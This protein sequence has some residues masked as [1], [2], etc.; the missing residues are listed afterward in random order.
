LQFAERELL[1][2]EKLLEAGKVT[3]AKVEK[4]R[5]ARDIAAAELERERGRRER[6]GPW[7]SRKLQKETWRDVG[8]STP[9]AALQTLLWSARE[10]D[11]DH[12]EA[13]MSLRGDG[14]RDFHGS[15]VA[16]VPYV[17]QR[18]KYCSGVTI[19][20][21]KYDGAGMAAVQM[22]IDGIPE[23]EVAIGKDIRM[24]LVNG[25]WKC[26]Y[27]HDSLIAF[28]TQI[29][30]K[31]G[32]ALTGPGVWT[33]GRREKEQWKEAGTSTPEGA[34]QRL[35][36]AAREKD[37]D[38]LRWVVSLP[39]ERHEEWYR[40]YTNDVPHVLER[41]KHC[42]GVTIEDADYEGT[43]VAVVRMVIDGIPAGQVA[44]SKQIRMILVDGHWKCD[45]PHDSLIAFKTRMSPAADSKGVS[46]E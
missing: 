6:V 45:Y 23:R 38:G 1:Q 35:L 40:S 2:A 13:M 28:K 8:A 17:L 31:S 21:V 39:R 27:P 46:T 32:E 41:V 36:W 12:L 15:Y 26:D 19:E 44:R 25:V 33:I 5:F 9:E 10:G 7:Q 22:A 18:V 29:R 11:V 4:A 34:L 37:M 16:D 14:D 42:S 43:G 30:R 3:R 24:I 20:G